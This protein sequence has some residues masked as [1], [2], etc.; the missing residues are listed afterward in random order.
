MEKLKNWF[1]G[2]LL[3]G[4]INKKEVLR[5]SLLYNI[6][7]YYFFFTLIVQLF[8]THLD[9]SIQ[10]ILSLIGSFSCV[11]P[12]FLLKYARSLKMAGLVF[13]AGNFLASAASIFVYHGGKIEITS[14]IWFIL[15]YLIA[16]LTMG[17]RAGMVYL[18][19]TFLL[20]C[21]IMAL[22]FFGI[23]FFPP[24]CTEE[25][26]IIATPFI[27]SN[28]FIV[29]Y[30]LTNQYIKSQKKLEYSLSETLGKSEILNKEL[31]ASEE[32]LRQSNEYQQQI[33]RKL[34][35]SEEKLKMAQKTAK[36]GSWELD[37]L[38]E[39]VYWS[40]ETCRIHDLPA[41]YVPNLET[42]IDFYDEYSKPLIKKAIEESLSTGKPWDLQLK[43]ISAKGIHKWVRAIGKVSFN[44]EGTHIIKLY[45]VFQDITEAKEKEIELE[46]YR[47]GLESLNAIAANTNLNHDEQLHEALKT[48][49]EY[50]GL[51]CGCIGKLNG[52][53]LEIEEYY[54][55]SN[56]T[57]ILKGAV[58]T[59]EKSFC[60]LTLQD[61]KAVAFSDVKQTPFTD[62]TCY[63]ELGFEAYIGAPV[64]VNGNK[65]GT[66]SFVSSQPKPE[67]F[68]KYDLSFLQVLANWIGSVIE[69]KLYEKE[70]LAAKE[71]AE[72]AAA[73]KAEFLST[74][75]HE[76]RTPM[77]A[78]IGMT[79]LLLQ[80]NP[81]TDQVENLQA[82]RFSG[83][84]LL[85]LI[86]DILDFSKIEAGRIEF[87]AAEFQI[88][89]LINSIK[90]SFH[91]RA[92][93]KGIQLK[94]LVDQQLPEV[95]IGDPT[96]LS[97]ILYNLVGNA[98]KF[99][100]QGQVV[101][102]VKVAHVLTDT[103]D[104]YFS[105]T[106]TGIGIAPKNLDMIFESFSQASQDVTRK[107]GGTG[108][109]LTI[110]KRLLE[111]QGSKVQVNSKEG[112]G[113][114][115]HF[116][117]SHGIAKTSV[118]QQTDSPGGSSQQQKPLNEVRI[119]LVEDNPVNVM[120]ASKFLN[121]W[122]VSLE[123]A[124]NGKI[125]L[126]KVNE[127][128]FDLVL[129]DLKMPVMDGYEA[130]KKIRETKPV[131]P[132][133]ALTASATLNAQEKVRQAGM[134][135]FLTKPFNPNEL[136]KLIVKHCTDKQI[137]EVH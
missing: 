93:E 95:V 124:E 46:H 28:A 99:T 57:P 105:V 78:V 54:S 81:R 53:N 56:N 32:E 129:M 126:E 52:P 82:L 77:N 92:E 27:I 47:D 121:T 4:T 87:E 10:V 31:V 26:Y 118:T 112:K 96:R 50:L 64:W 125:A 3:Q 134:N 84:N 120:V 90:Q 72:K 9:I 8:I 30:Y 100:H 67:E 18:V 20:L 127:R 107:F 25:E 65:Y 61:E 101:I 49:A 60:H 133:I 70:I 17:S 123:V 114:K 16:N 29:M 119:L 83:E 12:L 115:F 51:P 117:L 111:L 116:I 89:D 109:G 131:L 102:E 74:M 2:D 33:I 130:S 76:I 22:N 48:V 43:I 21:G 104:L 110:T 79:H 63:Q 19:V 7:L 97:Q 86:N 42:T 1:I 68:S 113:T 5:I 108:L 132:I 23:V 44:D 34:E 40:E 94:V 73:A 24:V 35:E 6:T 136:Y 71:T 88:K 69:R 13:I 62:S 14:G 15:L 103:I 137:P 98:V 106:D 39:K 45:G 11:I 122:E 80:E 59:L 38:R 36:I 85:A 91:F 41:D 55:I 37:A 66:V 58:L 128:D 75:S 135:G